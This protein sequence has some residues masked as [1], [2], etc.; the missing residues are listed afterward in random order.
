[1]KATKVK[2]H[3]FK[4]IAPC[5]Y[6]WKPT[7][8][9]YARINSR[10]HE[11]TRSL[12]T[13][14]RREASVKL[15]ELKS[16]RSRLDPGAGQIV[17]ATLVEKYRS[18]FAHEKPKTRSE[19]SLVLR[20]V[21]EGWPTGATSTPIT[22]IK[23]SDCTA[24]LACPWAFRLGPNARN[25]HIRILKNLFELAK[26]DHA[27][28][29]NPAAILRRTR[30]PSPIRL[31]PT[32]E[33]FRAIISS[34]RSQKFN[35]HGAEASADFLEAQGLLGL[36]Q[37]ELR[38]LVR[39]DVNLERGTLS[40]LRHKTG[41]RFVIPIY[42]G[43]RPLIEKVCAN[44]EHDWRLFEICN[45][46]KSLRGACRRLGLPA[47]SQ[48]SFRRMFV[49]RAI[50]LGVDVKVIA[51]WQGHRD[52]ALILRTYS[53]VRRPHAERM[54]KLMRFDDEENLNLDE[55]SAGLPGVVP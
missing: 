12:G 49:T 35:G 10:G 33:Q 47:Y 3:R 13:S 51:E 16:V 20:R 5:L 28:T 50:E 53:H 31:T 25:G 19:K 37:A 4:R 39:S 27:L 29:E 40:V 21:L 44:K 17:L 8:V 23:P 7:G 1:M 38:S 26:H 24:W 45:A 30:V 36:G 43:A 46:K 32:W 11:I 18:T 48:R 54:A 6:R 42:P 52:A 41:R 22:G 34:V 14:D 55:K 9:Y 15:A 2:K